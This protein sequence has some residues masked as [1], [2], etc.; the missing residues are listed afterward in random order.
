MSPYRKIHQII[1]LG[2][3]RVFVLCMSALQGKLKA[4][5]NVTVGF[6]K[7]PAAFI[8][9]LKGTELGKAVVKV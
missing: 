6:E 2:K 4:K 1:T 9:M 8:Q 7:M 5:E 3:T